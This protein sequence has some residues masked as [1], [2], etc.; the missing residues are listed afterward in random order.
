[1]LNLVNQLKL[2]CIFIH[3]LYLI[4]L[5]LLYDFSQISDLSNKRVKIQKYSLSQDN[6]RIQNIKEEI[7]SLSS[8]IENYLNTEYH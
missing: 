3:Y 5:A 6:K 1:M 2:Q 8:E 4:L 7:H